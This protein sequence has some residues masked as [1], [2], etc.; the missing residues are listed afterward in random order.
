[1]KKVTG[2]ESEQTHQTDGAQ[3]IRR[4]IKVLHAVASSCMKGLRLTDISNMVG[5]HVATTRRILMALVEEGILQLHPTQFTYSLG[6]QLL[7]FG[8]LA[9]QQ[10]IIIEPFR[11][12]LEEI[13]KRSGDTVLLSVRSDTNAICIL[14][15]EGAY[16]IR[17]MTLDVGS[18]RPLGAGAGSLALLA[19]LPSDEREQIMIFHEK[20]YRNFSITLE[21]IRV[22]GGSAR[23]VGYAMNDG[24]IL[25]GI[26]GV[27]IPISDLGGN[28][29]AA[30]SITAISSRLGVQR[31]R[32]LTQMVGE[33]CKNIQF[34]S[35]MNDKKKFNSPRVI[36]SCA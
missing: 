27:G 18:V 13:A 34:W 9:R 31:V 30:I 10:Q 14:R 26:S 36:K 3:S 24:L 2:R 7:Y 15:A 5:L 1:M 11:P 22:L 17:A 29:V 4:S 21:Q 25:D 23:E 16:P 6:P 19:W 32:E 33:V 28:V 35:V 20:N 8:E 12:C